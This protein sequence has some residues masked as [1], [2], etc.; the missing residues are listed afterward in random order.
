[1][2]SNRTIC[3]NCGTED[4]VVRWVGGG[5]P[6]LR[7]LHEL[8]A[9]EPCPECGKVAMQPVEMVH[10]GDAKDLLQQLPDDF[11]DAIVTSPPYADQR[12]RSYKGYPWQDA[13]EWMEQ[14]ASELLRVTKPGGG[15]MLNVGRVIKEGRERPVAEELRRAC[16]AADWDWI[17]SV[18][19]HKTNALPYSAPQY[20]H[21]VHEHVW[22]LGKGIDAYRGY[23]ADTRSPH[24]SGSLERMQQGYRHDDTERYRKRGK[25]HN[26]HPDGARPK[27]VF[28]TRIG[29][30]SGLKHSATMS[31][32][33][34][35]QLVSLSCPPGGL[36]LDPFCGAATTGLAAIQRGRRFLGFDLDPDAVD[37]GRQRLAAD[38][39]QLKLGEA[40]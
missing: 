20:L 37:E 4:E 11:A 29:A 8:C 13:F 40:A 18:I 17:D 7:D 38:A 21:P 3:T 32:E 19:W 30:Q 15:F 14:F 33:L 2:P 26:A 22:W 6:T 24:A 9:N 16:E 28:A 34:A 23:D 25:T 27:T 39:D 12:K 31:P 1:M 5:E 36:V 10:V 35:L